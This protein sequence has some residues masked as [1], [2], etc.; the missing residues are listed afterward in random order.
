MSVFFEIVKRK[1]IST[2]QS[3]EPDFDTRI[4]KSEHEVTKVRADSFFRLAPA[5][6][7]SFTDG[8]DQF[9]KFKHRTIQKG[10]P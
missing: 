4:T 3:E 9:V 10:P 8:K 5:E 7:V 6:F 1:S 2:S